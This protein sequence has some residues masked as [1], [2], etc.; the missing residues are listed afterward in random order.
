MAQGARGPKLMQTTPS[1]TQIANDLSVA[2]NLLSESRK[3]RKRLRRKVRKST[4]R[5]ADLYEMIDKLKISSTVLRTYSGMFQF[6][7]GIRGADEV[8]VFKATQEL[9]YER[10]QLR[11][12]LA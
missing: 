11:K 5:N 6:H 9:S 7:G 2:E 8:K 3:L 1:H 12:M 4:E 10:N